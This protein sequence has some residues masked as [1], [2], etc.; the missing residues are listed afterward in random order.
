M[1]DEIVQINEDGELKVDTV[2]VDAPASGTV[3][4]PDS[5]TTES[6]EAALQS[7]QAKTAAFFDQALDSAGKFFNNNQQ[8]LI[9][10]GWVLLALVG[11]KLL[12]TALDVVNDI[13]LISPLF[14]LIGLIYSGWFVW[15]YLLRAQTRQEL[16]QMLDR[17]KSE[18]LGDR[19]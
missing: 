18:L 2:Q 7:F 8:L 16:A 6:T 12:F 1:T 10:L 3:S 9:S 15:R 17:T 5:S 19:N 13:P 11:V 4:F 14:R